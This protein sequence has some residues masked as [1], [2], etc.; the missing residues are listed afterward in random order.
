M[1]ERELFII[2]TIMLAF[3][4]TMVVIQIVIGACIEDSDREF[5][6]EKEQKNERTDH[7]DS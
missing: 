6:D 3:N 2:N 5:F 7:E 4:V 1:T